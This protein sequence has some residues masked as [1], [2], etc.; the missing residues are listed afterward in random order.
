MEAR[1]TDLSNQMTA[2]YRSTL[3]HPALFY[4]G[5][6]RSGG[7]GFAKAGEEISF[8]FIAV[9][10]AGEKA[11][12]GLFLQSGED[13]GIM[14]VELIREEW[15]RVQQR[16]ANGYMYDQY[17]QEQVVEGTQRISLR[18]G[19]LKVTPPRAGF[20]T[21]RAGALDREGKAAL[22]EISF[23]ATGSGGGWCNMNNADELRLTPDQDMYNPGDTARLLLQSPLPAG[24]Y[25]ITL[26]RE[27]IFT[28]ETLH[29]AEPS[30]V[31]EIPIARNIVPLVYAAVSSYS[32]RSGPPAHEYGSPDLDKPKGYF[33]VT[34]L[35]VNPRTRAFSVK[36]ESDKKTYRPGDEVAL[37]LTAERGG[38]P[39][40]NAELTLLA[41]DRGVLDL[42]D[43]HVPDPIAYFY[44]PDRFPLAV[45]GG[46]S[47]SWLMDPV[48]YSV[49]N[50]AGGDGGGESKLEER[51][52]FNPTAVFEPMLL[53]GADGKVRY[54]FKLPDN[55]TAYRVTVFGVRGDIFAL[56]ESEI[57]VRNRINVREVLPR[58]LRERDTAEAGVLITNLDS[59]PHTISV[60][61]DISDPQDPEEAETGRRKQKGAAF[62]DGPA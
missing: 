38:R 17:V 32:I 37:T 27:G 11:A 46:D 61:L 58:R 29:L 45:A 42:I 34:K 14:T 33:G 62:V 56:K 44:N 1:V 24:L 31:I 49:K 13:A 36:V 19:A 8:D 9:N 54:T 5:L 15:R 4:I 12:G 18:N 48:T 51:N 25:L 59:A 6:A 55:L 52:D 60:G 21:L 3:V 2:A 7:G 30:S 10:P 16:G 40:P 43:Y 22:T 20:Y 57:A 28:E 39:L 47:R 41:V 35:M 26:E 23:Y 53:T 50:L